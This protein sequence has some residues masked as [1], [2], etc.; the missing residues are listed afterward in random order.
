MLEHRAKERR[1]NAFLHKDCIGDGTCENGESSE[2]CSINGDAEGRRQRP[3]SVIGC[4][5]LFSPNAEE[6]DDCLPS[7]SL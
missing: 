7:V 4:V 2:G 6:K 3:V 1:A 5:D